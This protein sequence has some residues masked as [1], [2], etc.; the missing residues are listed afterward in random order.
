[1]KSL[2]I[3]NKKAFV[4]EVPDPVAEKEWV[5]VKIETTPI[6]GSDKGP[7]FGDKPIRDAGHEGSGIVVDAGGSTLLKKG[8]R[9]ILNPLSG[10]GHCEPCLTG[11]YIYCTE[12]PPFGT[13]FA[14]F[15]KVQDFVC[16]ILPE[17]ISYDTGAMACCALGPAFNAIKRMHLRAFDNLLVTGLG[18]VGMGA[19]AIAKFLG[20]KV[21]ALDTV[22]FRKKM[23]GEVLGADIVL[24][25]A[26]PDIKT[27]IREATKQRRLTRAIDASGNASAERLCIDMMEPGGM[28]AFVGENHGDIPISPSRDFIRKGLTLIGSW[29]YNLNDRADMINLLRRSPLVPK[30][31]THTF[32]FSKVQEAFETFVGGDACKVILKPWE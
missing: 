18:P 21:I 2:V 5:V 30:L 1:M 10:C 4:E 9:V 24:D 16:T 13:H 6:C 11:N 20:V 12:K 15:V 25:A 8:D 27:Q 23:A 31:I 19:V 32:G 17:D 7:F 28:I 14:Q 22:S 26:D 29:H 3:G